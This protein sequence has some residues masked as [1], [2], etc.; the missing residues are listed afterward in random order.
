LVCSQQIAGTILGCLPVLIEC[1]LSC[2]RARQVC[3]RDSLYPLRYVYLVIAVVDGDLIGTLH[4]IAAIHTAMN[5]LCEISFLKRNYM[6]FVLAS[7]AWLVVALIIL[8]K[9]IV[10]GCIVCQ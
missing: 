9:N 6:F 1:L 7:V 10:L 2:A 3:R 8:I 4:F 5:L